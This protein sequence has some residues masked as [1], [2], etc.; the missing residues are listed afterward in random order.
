MMLAFSEHLFVILCSKVY[1]PIGGEATQPQNVP[2]LQ[3]Y[4][5][6]KCKTCGTPSTP[7]TLLE[8]RFSPRL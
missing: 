5:S 8:V 6:M 2:T 7:G 3:A 4:N 1:I